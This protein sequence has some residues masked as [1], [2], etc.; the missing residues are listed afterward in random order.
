MAQWIGHEWCFTINA[1]KNSSEEEAEE[2]LSPLFDHIR[3]LDQVKYVVVK[4]ECGEFGNF[5]LQGFIILVAKLTMKEIKALFHCQTIHLE[6]RSNKSTNAQAAAYV[7]KPETYWPFFP[8]YEK[9]SLDIV[10]GCREKSGTGPWRADHYNG[11]PDCLMMRI[12]AFKDFDEF[13][14]TNPFIPTG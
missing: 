5:H 14:R 11:C 10:T 7:K 1:P 6:K 8:L 4:G 13:Q 12:A 3:Q 9:G 2:F